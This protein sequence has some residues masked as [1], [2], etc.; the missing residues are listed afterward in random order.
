[1]TS[2]CVY[3]HR[4]GSAP[5][6]QLFPGLKRG[7]VTALECFREPERKLHW[8]LTKP[9][10]SGWREART[11]INSHGTA[12]LHME[13]APIRPT[14]DK[15]LKKTKR[16][17]FNGVSEV[18]DATDGRGNCNHVISTLFNHG[19]SLN[20]TSLVGRFKRQQRGPSD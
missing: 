5:R 13:M 19:A 15:F 6:F 18:R 8:L 4:F 14:H 1:M 17:S 16:K 11:L 12:T 20:Y 2:S 3:Y 10:N 7:L 9:L